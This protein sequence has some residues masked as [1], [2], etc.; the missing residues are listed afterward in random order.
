MK[1]KIKK[2]QRNSKFENGELSKILVLG[3]S[4]LEDSYK[5]IEYNE[6]TGGLNHN[7]SSFNQQKQ[8][9]KVTSLGRSPNSKKNS[10]YSKSLYGHE[11]SNTLSRM[12]R[13][14]FNKKINL[15]EIILADSGSYISSMGNTNLSKHPLDQK[16][17]LLQRE[18]MSR[19]SML[20]P[21]G[22]SGGRAPLHFGVDEIHNK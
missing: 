4:K 18:S 12:T 9:K 1:E 2:K 15:K 13:D 11:S 19:G 21:P 16:L 6:R 7:I 8:S 10:L 17:H 22:T 3:S 20:K 14:S 5:N